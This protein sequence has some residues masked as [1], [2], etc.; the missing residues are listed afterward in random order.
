LRLETTPVER[1]ITSWQSQYTR[2]NNERT[3]SVSGGKRW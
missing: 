2:H 3:I 1:L